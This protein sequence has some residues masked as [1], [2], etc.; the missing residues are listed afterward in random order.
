MLSLNPVVLHGSSFAGQ[1]KDDVFGVELNSKEIL[2]ISKPTN[3]NGKGRIFL[4]MASRAIAQGLWSR[5]EEI[6]AF[7]TDR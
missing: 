7:P 5:I 3:S 1:T 2:T 6:R 4:E